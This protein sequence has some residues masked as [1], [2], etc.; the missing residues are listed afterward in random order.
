MRLFLK[1]LFLLLF[2]FAIYAKSL[3]AVFFF[4]SRNS[5]V[6]YPLWN[7]VGYLLKTLT[8]LGCLFYSLKKVILQRSQETT[9]HQKSRFRRLIYCISLFV[10]LLAFLYEGK[11]LLH[12]ISSRI[13]LEEAV[14]ESIIFLFI[15]FCM[16]Q[17][18]LF[19][20]KE[21]D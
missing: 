17:T 8:I 9:K 18:A 21:I 5:T 13:S 7:D 2:S 16:L 10:L 3:E 4:F 12:L 1:I 20:K 14:V 15:C 19:L 11:D 6:H